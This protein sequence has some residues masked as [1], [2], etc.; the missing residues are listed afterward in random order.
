MFPFP[1]CLLF[2]NPNRVAE[3]VILNYCKV[4]YNRIERI[5][6]ATKIISSIDYIS[7]FW[8]SIGAF[9]VST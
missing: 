8:L 4:T 2:K 3:N 7:N 6:K 5:L 1:S 9:L